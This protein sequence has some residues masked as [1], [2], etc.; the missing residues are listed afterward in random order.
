MILIKDIFKKR[1]VIPAACF[2]FFLAVIFVYPSDARSASDETSPSGKI[3]KAI[4]SGSLK[5]EIGIYY[6]HI[7]YDR[8]SF[9]EDEE[10]IKLEESNLVVPYF[11]ADYLSPEYRDFSIGIGLTGYT[12]INDNQHQ[13]DRISDFD[14]FVFHQLILNYDIS[15]TTIRLGRQSIE[16]SLF[17]NDYY[18]ALSINYGEIDNII[19]NLFLVR[20]VAESDIDKFIKFENINRGNKTVDDFLYAVEVSWDIVPDS[21]DAI[22][23]YYHQGH[24]YDLYGGHF[25]LSHDFEGLGFGLNLDYYTT[26][27]DSKNGMRNI[28]DEVDET[29]IYHIN[30]HLELSGFSITA[31]YIRADRL[32]GVREG[33]LIDDYFNPFNEGNNVYD[34]DARTW[35]WG[36]GYEHENFDIGIILGRTDYIDD[37]RRLKEKEFDITAGITFKERFRL[38]TEFARVYS[39]SPEGDFLLLETA[40]TYEF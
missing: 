25:S 37:G 17:L 21:L 15:E 16:D 14:R 34:P 10:I 8:G 39:D 3:I 20:G 40:L 26:D 29:G 2:V 35:Y 11:R 38:E 19:L 18:E 13:K 27:E 1:A 12:H 6:E 28:N 36:L 33:G 30:P 32:S 22:F 5:G 9:T 4:R 7:N 24:L 31:G 23:Y